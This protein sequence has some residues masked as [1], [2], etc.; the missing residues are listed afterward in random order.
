MS[1]GETTLPFDL[2]IL[3]PLRMT[4][5]WVKSRVAGSS[6]PIKPRSRITLVQK[7]E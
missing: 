5:P 2:D 4:I 3:A 6:L 7:R 1:S